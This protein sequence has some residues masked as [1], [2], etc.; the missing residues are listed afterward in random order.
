MACFWRRWISRHR[1]I[2]GTVRLGR[3]PSVHPRGLRPA[4]TLPDVPGAGSFRERKGRRMGFPGAQNIRR[5]PQDLGVARDVS[6]PRIGDL[7]SDRVL[8]TPR[9]N[10]RRRHDGS[11]AERHLG[12]GPCGKHARRRGAWATP[13]TGVMGQ[14][15]TVSTVD[16]EGHRQLSS[17]RHQV[18]PS[19]RSYLLGDQLRS[20]VSITYSSGLLVAH[21]TSAASPTESPVRSP[22]AS[23]RSLTSFRMFAARRSLIS[24]HTCSASGRW[25]RPRAAPVTA[26]PGALG[27]LVLRVRR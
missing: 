7:A 12:R 18:S 6:A 22:P 21:T 8:R 11:S 15:L 16:S 5:R 13:G 26:G 23:R 25:M 17:S 1:A 19:H 10:D 9:Q 14:G 4:D 20:R 2:T 27:S 3:G 24:F